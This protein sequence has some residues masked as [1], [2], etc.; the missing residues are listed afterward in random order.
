MR[1]QYARGH[2]ARQKVWKT[3]SRSVRLTINLSATGIK[4]STRRSKAGQLFSVFAG[5]AI[6]K[7]A[8]AVDATSTLQ[9]IKEIGYK[10]LGPRTSI[11]ACFR[12]RSAID[13]RLPLCLAYR[14]SY[15]QWLGSFAYHM[16]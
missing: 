11:L 3:I 13:S 15:V 12:E 5:M 14:Y 1:K 9:R 7:A 16:I 4:S 2:R 6:L 10:V 8:L